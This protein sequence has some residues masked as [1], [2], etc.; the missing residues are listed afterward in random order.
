[1]KLASRPQDYIFSVDQDE[2]VK[3]YGKG[4][5]TIIFLKC[6]SNQQLIRQYIVSSKNSSFVT[7]ATT[8]VIICL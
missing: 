7:K 8:S 1:M 4:N 6:K 3:F 5:L 2:Q